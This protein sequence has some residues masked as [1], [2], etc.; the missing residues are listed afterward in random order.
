[1]KFTDLPL[2][3]PLQ[4]TIAEKGFTE[5]TSIQKTCIPEILNRKDIVGQAETGIQIGRAHV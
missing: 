5:L 3:T 1:M 2:H 4:K